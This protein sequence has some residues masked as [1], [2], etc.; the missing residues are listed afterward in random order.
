MEKPRPPKYAPVSSED[1][2]EL[3]ELG[4][5]IERARLVLDTRMV[6]LR[7]KYK[8]PASLILTGDGDWIPPQNK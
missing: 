8:A 4:R 1:M 2:T 5:A 6:E 3:H 7:E